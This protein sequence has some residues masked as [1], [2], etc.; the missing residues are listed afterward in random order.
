M[1]RIPVEKK[2]GSAW[3]LWLL[4]LLVL[5]LGAW[6]L[7]GA[8]DDDEGAVAISGDNDAVAPMNE[9][10]TVTAEA[11]TGGPITDLMTL[12]EA[13]DPQALVGRQ[14]RLS[15]VTASTVS[16]DSTYW[17]YNPDEGVERRVFTVL[18]ALGESNPGPGTGAD[19]KFNV[20]EGET[21]TVEGVVQAVQPSDPD[22]WGVT[23]EVE[24]ELRVEQIYIRARSLENLGT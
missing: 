15:G 13:D 6:L 24:R 3:W 12:L 2:S 7:I 11:T 20:D 14:V 4:G 22:S 10:A 23:G 21:M 5:G 1:A 18:Y 16:G 17:V 9:T 19:G 8:L